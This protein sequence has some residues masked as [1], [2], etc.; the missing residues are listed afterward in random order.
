M[1]TLA[2]LLPMQCPEEQQ[3]WKGGGGIYR[4]G[5]QEL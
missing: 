3:H 4:A 1:V 5:G 2:S